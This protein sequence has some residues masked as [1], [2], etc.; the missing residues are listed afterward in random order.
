M[1][2]WLEIRKSGDFNKMAQEYGIDPLIARILTNRDIKEAD[3]AA[4][5]QG[6]KEQLHNPHTLKDADKGAQLVADKIK[7][8]A[9]IRVIGDYDIDGVN[10]TY[11]LLSGL[12]RCGANVDAAIPDRM[13]DGYG[14]NENLIE[15]A[16]ED[17][18]DTIITCDN[19]IAALEAIDYAKEQGMTVVVTDHH[20]IP[21]QMQADIKQYLSSKA[22]AIINPKQEEC[23]YPYKELCGAA[24]A[25]KFLQVLYEKTGIPVEEADV[26]IE[27]AGFATVGDVMDLTGENRILVKLGLKALEHT[28]NPGMRALMLQNN[29]W[30]K[31]L[32]AYHIDFV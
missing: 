6:T 3:M 14:I 24:V 27:N 19:G 11:I 1:E 5:L 23:G 17:D 20:D 10:A 13:K 7:T 21:Y 9:K 15:K 8:G 4:Y 22:D 32:S 31:P 30:D 25:F 16:K 29:L 2:K 18:V 28:K 26:F 12:M